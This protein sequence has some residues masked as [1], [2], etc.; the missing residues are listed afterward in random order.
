MAQYLIKYLDG[1]SETITAANVRSIVRQ[2]TEAVD[3]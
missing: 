1:E 2:D 3:A